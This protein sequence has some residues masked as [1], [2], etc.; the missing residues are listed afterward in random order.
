[1]H[2]ISLPLH[3]SL[4]FDTGIL[5]TLKICS[6]NCSTVGLPSAASSSILYLSLSRT[7]HM[8]TYFY[9]SMQ[10]TNVI[11]H[12]GWT[13]S[14]IVGYFVPVSESRATCTFLACL[15]TWKS[16][17]WLERWINHEQKEN[18]ATTDLSCCCLFQGRCLLMCRAH[19]FPRKI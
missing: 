2:I 1:M 6:A 14:C 5:V 8:I 9:T 13:I 19:N 7:E 3:I 16:S 18:L 10:S 15:E 11:F 4:W 17:C 12:P